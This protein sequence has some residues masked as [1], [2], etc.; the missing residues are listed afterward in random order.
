[1]YRQRSLT[2]DFCRTIGSEIDERDRKDY[3]SPSTDLF[4]DYCSSVIQ[5][6]AL[7]E[8]G[9]ILKREATHLSYDHLFDSSDSKV[10][11]I[12]TSTGEKF[13]SRAVVLAVGPGG[14][15][16]SKIYPWKPSTEQE[17]A[18]AC[19]HSMEIK[20]FPSPSVQKKI[21]RRQETN[22]VVVGGGLSSAQ[23]VDMAIRKGVTKVWFLMRSGLKGMYK[24]LIKQIL[25][26]Y[27]MQ[28]T[29]KHFDISLPWMGKYKNWEK[30]AFWSADTDEGKFERPK[31][32][33][34]N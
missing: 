20:T 4:S 30:A 15:G 16:V 28:S 11:T 13:Y 26:K 18:A 29:V 10:F 24:Y 7:D 5:R 32:Q 14:A 3:F 27:L 31:L 17:G 23:I 6:Y 25:N 8:P 21:Q 22:V 12:A 1:L 34:P 2:I 19:C 33:A 9:Q